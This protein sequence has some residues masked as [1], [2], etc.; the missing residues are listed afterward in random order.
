[1]SN[2]VAQSKSQRLNRRRFVKRMAFG[3]GALAAGGLSYALIEASWIAIRRTT[4]SLPQLSKEFAG[5]KIV[6]ITLA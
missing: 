1:M 3:G 6:L 2:D 4:I 5:T